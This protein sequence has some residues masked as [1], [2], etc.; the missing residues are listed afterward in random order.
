MSKRKAANSAAA[1]RRG[2]RPGVAGPALALLAL[3]WA[4]A[5]G[6]VRAD[7]IVLKSGEVLEGSIIDAT[8]NTV[9]VQ[10]AIGGMRQMSIREIEEVRIELAQGQQV[11]GQLLSW[12]EGVYQVRSGGQVL[13]IGEGDILS[14]EP[15]GPT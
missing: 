6:D 7:T 14:H 8:R 2:R 10:R 5:P 12:A 4:G 15:G 1:S 3:A 11:S 13:R 9:V